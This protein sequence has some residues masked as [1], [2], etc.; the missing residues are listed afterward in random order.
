MGALLIA[1]N[2]GIA[3]LNFVVCEKIGDINFFC[4]VTNV[5]VA[6]LLLGMEI[7]K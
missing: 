2:V 7:N 6:G 3:V 1:F 5:F 4:A